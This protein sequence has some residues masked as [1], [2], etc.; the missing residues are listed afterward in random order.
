MQIMGKRIIG[1]DVFL[2]FFMHVRVGRKT[3]FDV[4]AIFC[5]TVQ[6]GKVSGTGG[7]KCRASERHILTIKANKAATGDIGKHLWPNR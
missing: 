7:K 5:R 4:Y 6:I 1:A 2:I 3:A